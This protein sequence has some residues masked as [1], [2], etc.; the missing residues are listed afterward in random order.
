MAAL[1]RHL[2]AQVPAQALHADKLAY[3]HRVLRES[4][5]VGHEQCLQLQVCV[6]TQLMCMCQPQEAYDPGV[7]YEVIAAPCTDNGGGG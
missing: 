7:L 6:C 5:E 1:E 4:H 3:N 2:D